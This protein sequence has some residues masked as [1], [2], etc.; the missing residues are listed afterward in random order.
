MVFLHEKNAPHKHIGSCWHPHRY[1]ATLLHEADLPF[2]P[3]FCGKRL[4]TLR[5]SFM[6]LPSS[7][8]F[9]C[10]D[11]CKA[12]TSSASCRRGGSRDLYSATIAMFFWTSN[13][14]IW[15]MIKM[16]DNYVNL[17]KITENNGQSVSD[18]FWGLP[19][20]PLVF[21]SNHLDVV[22]ASL[23]VCTHHPF[24]MPLKAFLR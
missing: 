14:Q 17:W 2:F 8:S 20:L 10:K 23:Q 7:S 1:A 3:K 15:K 5:C 18:I 6:A 24:N 4:A 13:L 12:S 9:A 19:V 21:F 22:A 16:M 11:R